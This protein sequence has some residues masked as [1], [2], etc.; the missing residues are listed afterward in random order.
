MTNRF[1]IQPGLDPESVGA[2]DL[3]WDTITLEQYRNPTPAPTGQ[4]PAPKRRGR[5]DQRPRLGPSTYCPDITPILTAAA[6]VFAVTQ[7]EIRD[8][9]PQGAPRSPQARRARRAVMAYL[10]ATRGPTGARINSYPAIGRAFGVHHTS[11]MSAAHNALP[12]DVAD[13]AVELEQRSAAA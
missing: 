9:T 10:H 13:L 4:P 12:S 2:P 1:G 8:K 11:V 5:P 7:S 3:G 6:T